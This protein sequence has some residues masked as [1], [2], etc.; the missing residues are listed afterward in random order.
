M[1]LVGAAS[2]STCRAFRKTFNNLFY[3]N[4][5]IKPIESL[6]STNRF[7]VSSNLNPLSANPENWSNT[8]KQIVGNLPTICLSVFDHF[9]NLAPKGLNIYRNLKYLNLNK[10]IVKI[11]KILVDSWNLQA[12]VPNDESLRQYV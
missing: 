1:R 11:F 6:F 4:F 8:L 12:L 2:L 5:A 9:M 3:K 10:Y 7:Q